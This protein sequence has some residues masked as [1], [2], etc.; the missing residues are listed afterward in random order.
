M[1]ESFLHK[2]RFVVGSTA[3]ENWKILS[4]A[5]QNHIWFHLDKS[6]SPYV[7][8]EAS[9]K[10]LEKLVKKNP[11]VGSVKDFIYHA[12]KLCKENS[13]SKRMNNVTIIYTE[14]KNV[15]KGDVTGEAILKRGCKKI[16]I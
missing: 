16:K 5:K 4:K 14:V 8:L 15:S 3:E 2:V 10:E 12:G 9:F 11:D 1:K 13:K 7:I 6:A